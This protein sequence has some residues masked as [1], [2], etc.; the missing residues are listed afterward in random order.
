MLRNLD[1]P[2][3]FVDKG[4]VRGERERH[5]PGHGE[6]RRAV[7]TTDLERARAILAANYLPLRV[8]LPRGVRSVEANL[9]TASLGTITI[10]HLQFAN[11]TRI[12]TDEASN[13]HVNVQLAG[14]SVSSMGSRGEVAC[15]PG[16]AVVFS[17][18]AAADLHWSKG[19]YKLCV[20]LDAPMLRQELGALLGHE[21]ARPL[22]FANAMAFRGTAASAWTRVLALVDEQ[23]RRQSGMLSQPLIA[24]RLTLLLVDALLHCQPHNYSDDLRTTPSAAPRGTAKRALDLMHGRP[25]HPW[26]TREIAAE[27]GVSS[28]SLQASLRKATGMTPTSVLR[29]IRLDRAHD[30]LARAEASVTTIAEIAHRWGF[31][32]LGRFAGRYQARFGVHP[33]DT[34]RNKK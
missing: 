13:Y 12:R 23:T 34:L 33:S 1:K 31:A 16:S 19:T 15:A 32:H 26:S 22:V 24:A 11:E 6:V 5:G 14:H 29:D 10:G 21:P 18:G 4:G 27:V 8:E 30:E 25:E 7:A 20:M 2:S 28:R 17:P 9:D 3:R